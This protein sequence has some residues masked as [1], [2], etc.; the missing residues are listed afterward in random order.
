MR[1]FKYPAT[2]K[3]FKGRRYMVLCKSTPIK[4]EDLMHSTFNINP[5]KCMHTEYNSEVDI[6]Y[7]L[8]GEYH[9]LDSTSS[10]DL[11]VYIALYGNCKVYA[12]PYDMFMSEVDKDKYPNSEHKYRFEEVE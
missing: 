1:E 4:F 3:H 2:Y 8:N 11:V 12:R 10:E 6:Y 5:L 7:F 9:H